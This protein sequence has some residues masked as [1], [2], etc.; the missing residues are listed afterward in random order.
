MPSC[1]RGIESCAIPSS[2][3]RLR[4]D[5][6]EVLRE[7]R[8]FHGLQD[9][10]LQTIADRAIVRRIGRGEVLFSQGEQAQGLYL[11]AEGAFRSIR[12]TPEGRE[13]VVSTK[14]NGAALAEAAVFDGSKTFYTVIAECP[15]IVL[16]IETR[17]VYQ[18]CRDY[19]A[20]FWNVARDLAHE[21]RRSAELIETLALRSVEQRLA[22]YVLT[23][24]ETH[25]I[26]S[27]E[28]SIVE[29]TAT[30]PEIAIRLGS[31]REV[32]SRSFA[33]LQENG[34]IVLRGRLIT[35]PD[36]STLRAFA[37]AEHTGNDDC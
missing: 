11:V 7:T 22:Q 12:Q 14:T 10:A 6:T 17:D 15:S 18:F 19:P 8:L 25:G 34:L 29:L 33:R 36:E 27:T 37:A 3:T 9:A 16:F 26:R 23:L 1:G 21:L 31:V 30:R 20:V 4:L 24:V 13:Q 28:G 5:K 32:I 35:V 2:Y